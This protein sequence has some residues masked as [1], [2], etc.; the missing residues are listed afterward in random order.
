LVYQVSIGACGLALPAEIGSL[1]LRSHTQAI[2]GFVQVGLGWVVSFV[3]PYIINPDAGNLGGKI[4]YIFFGFGVIVTI[5]LFFYCPETKGLNYD[6]VRQLLGN[7]DCIDRLFVYHQD[8][9]PE[10]PGDNQ[11]ISR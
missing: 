7:V 8:K 5:L 4:G 9:S 3:I 6:E 11:E 1:P 10:I 2:T